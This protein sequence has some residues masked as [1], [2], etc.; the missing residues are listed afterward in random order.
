[1]DRDPDKSVGSLVK[2][3]VGHRKVDETN[4]TNKGHSEVDDADKS[5]SSLADKVKDRDKR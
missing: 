2:H 1:M 4:K 5:I 3:S